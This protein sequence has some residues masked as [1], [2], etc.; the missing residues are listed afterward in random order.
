MIYVNIKLND[1]V[2]KH[3]AIQLNKNFSRQYLTINEI[4]DDLKRVYVDLNKIFSRQYLTI[5]EI[6]DDLK[7]VYVDLN[8]MQF[9]MKAFIKLV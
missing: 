8:K 1:E 9:V 4:F 2:Y 3:I 7:R 5:N 6:F